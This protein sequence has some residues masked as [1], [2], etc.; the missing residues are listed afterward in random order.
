MAVY[1]DNMY[2]NP[3]GQ[4]GR[5][6]MSHMAA[7]THDELIAMAKKIGVNVKWIQD[8]GKGGEHFD[9]AMSKRE[10]AIQFGAIPL[11]MFTLCP[12]MVKRKSPNDKLNFENPK[13]INHAK[14]V[15]RQ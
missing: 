4:F 8:E 1:V 14:H 3:I 13:K 15:P 12:A 2:E 11:S 5:M 6:K 9:I 7:D 10:K